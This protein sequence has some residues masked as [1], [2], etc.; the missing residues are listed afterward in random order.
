MEVIS[1]QNLGSVRKCGTSNGAVGVLQEVN[2][3]LGPFAINAARYEA[4][5]FTW[6]VL[7]MNVKVFAGR[8]SPEIDPWGFLLP[9]SPWVWGALLAFL[10]LLALF[11]FLLSSKFST[12]G[13]NSKHLLYFTSIML[14]ECEKLIIDL[15][16]YIKLFILLCRK[17]PSYASNAL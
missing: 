1:M 13:L 11:S 8:K 3:A 14:R 17:N 2:M 6:P 16:N 9:L 5:D 15:W 4:V 7:Y 10:L 12:H